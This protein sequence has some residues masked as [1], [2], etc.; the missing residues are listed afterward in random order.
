[1]S[2]SKLIIY[3][4]GYNYP[5]SFEK[6]DL[7]IDIL[8][9]FMKE[10]KI[11]LRGH[12]FISNGKKISFRYLEKK[13]IK[14]QDYAGKRIFAF[15]LIKS[16]VSKDWKLENILCPECKN[17][18]F[19]TYNDEIITLEC[20][21]CT[22]K[23]IYSLNEFMDV[24]YESSSFRC[25]E[26]KSIN[27]FNDKSKE[28]YI[29]SECNKKLC[30][31]CSLGHKKVSHNIL[32]FKFQYEYCAKDLAF[33]ENYCNTC[34]CNY[35]P[36]EAKDHEKHSMLY[37][38][39]KKPK[40]KFIKEFKKMIEEL[41]KKIIN[42][43]NELKLLKELFD[44][45]MVNM[46]K[47]IDSHLKLNDYMNNSADNLNN[48]QKIKN[49]DGFLYKKF[50]KEITNFSNFEIKNKFLYIIEKFYSKNIPYDQI[51]L[52]YAPKSNKKIQILGDQFVEQNQG[53]C[54]LIIK[55]K[56]MPLIQYYDYKKKNNF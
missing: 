37:I 15:N 56:I 34:H 32:E 10:M 28:S 53:N 42:Y 7:F 23:N 47:N 48:Y 46:I 35:C 24:Q 16:K 41:N 22:K 3:Y 9:K 39:D 29:C 38:K 4:N 11:D 2:S 17:L 14:A 5:R 40:E 1:M 19:I 50:L 49:I 54:L 43:R 26:C 33:F 36:K 8:K 6:N 21:K 18:A 52:S 31:I 45:M 12:Y 30:A 20:K 27:N 25:D 55:D 13:R 51:E 44:R